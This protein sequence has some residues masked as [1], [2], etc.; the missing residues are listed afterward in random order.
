[1]LNLGNEETESEVVRTDP[2]IYHV[3]K[4]NNIY[5]TRFLAKGHQ[6]P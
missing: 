5:F 2:V 1:M 4:V 3:W 6:I